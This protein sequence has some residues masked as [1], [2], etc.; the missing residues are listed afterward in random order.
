MFAVMFAILVLVLAVPDA[1]LPAVCELHQLIGQIL[2]LASD[3]AESL[4]RV[5]APVDPSAHTYMPLAWFSD[6]SAHS[7]QSATIVRQS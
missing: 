1:S 7:G 2:W 4:L 3:G 5:P 6:S